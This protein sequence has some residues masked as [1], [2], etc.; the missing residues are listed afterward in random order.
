[1]RVAVVDVGS[2]TVRLLV[3][4]RRNGCLEPV[5]EDRAYLRLGDEVERLGWIS[6]PKLRATVECVRAYARAARD[7]GAHHLEVVV[8]APG[9]RAANADELVEALAAGAGGGV[10]VLTSEQEAEYA[11]VGALSRLDSIPDSVAVCDSGGGSTELVV[12]TAKGP[13][14]IRSVDV[15]SLTVRR[16]LPDDPPG[17]RALDDAREVVRRRLEGFAPPLPKAAYATGGTARALRRLV[18]RRLGRD[19][20]VEAFELLGRTSSAALAAEHGLHPDRAWSLVGGAVVLAEV[21]ARIGVPLE[22]ARAGMREGVAA[23]AF[24]ELAAA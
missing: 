1:M 10:R 12:G 22:V 8:T 11:F 7:A 19:E 14:W 24:A 5:L 23:V 21:Q 17:A 4:A 16:L 13:Q 20:L 6:E 9:R 2:N 3:A 18:G 15:G